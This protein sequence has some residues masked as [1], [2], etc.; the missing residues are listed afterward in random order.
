MRHARPKYTLVSHWHTHVSPRYTL[1]G[2]RHTFMC[3]HL[4]YTRQ[5]TSYTRMPSL[6]T[7]KSTSYTHSVTIN[8]RKLTSYVSMHWRYKNYLEKLIQAIKDKS[9]AD[10]LLLNIAKT[11]ISTTTLASGIIIDTEITCVVKEFSWD[12]RN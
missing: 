2:H 7:R 9:K 8:T 6:H 4:L 11:A 10:G 12:K 1:V 5:S 3:M